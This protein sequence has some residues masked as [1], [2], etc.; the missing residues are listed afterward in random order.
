MLKK[1]SYLNF[2]YFDQRDQ[3]NYYSSF[4]DRKRKFR[5]FKNSINKIKAYVYINSKDEKKKM[6]WAYC[7]KK[8]VLNLEKKLNPNTT[9][10]YHTNNINSIPKNRNFIDSIDIFPTKIIMLLMILIKI[11]HIYHHLIN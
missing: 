3:C 5:H 4:N 2:E 9:P 1:I 10:R 11:I 8:E 7:T 6:E